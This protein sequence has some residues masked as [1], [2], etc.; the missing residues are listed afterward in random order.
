MLTKIF[1]T[2][3]WHSWPCLLWRTLYNTKKKYTFISFFFFFSFYQW[4]N[5]LYIFIKQRGLFGSQ[6]CRFQGVVLASTRA[7]VKASCRW[8]LGNRSLC[9]RGTT[10]P[11]NNAE[12]S[13]GNKLASFIITLSIRIILNKTWWPHTRP[14]FLKAPLPL[15]LPH[16][17]PSF[18][19]MKFWGSN[20]IH[21]V[22]GPELWD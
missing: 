10:L 11:G 1:W 14:H 22:A 19:P 7:L 17:E 6:F 20:N 21:T 13:G 16:W 12:R 5:R 2:I 3:S 18:Q 4:K 9:R 8:H 15:T